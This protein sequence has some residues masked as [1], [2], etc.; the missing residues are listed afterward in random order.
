[1]RKQYRAKGIS[2]KLSMLGILFMIPALCFLLIDIVIPFAWNSYISFFDYNGVSAMKLSGFDNYR[3]VLSNRTTMLSFMNSVYIALTMASIALVVGLVLSIML[4]KMGQREGSFYRFVIFVPGMIPFTVI[5]LLFA[6]ILAPDIGLVNNLLKILH[7]GHLQRAWL[8][9]KG[10]VVW[11]IAIVAGWRTCGITMMLFYTA[12]LKIPESMFEAARIEGADYFRQVRIIVLPLLKRTIQVVSMLVLM[13]SF[14]T[15]DIVY[16]MSGGGPGNASIIVPIRMIE[17]AFT[18]NRF[19]SSAAM[20]VC[21]TVLVSAF[22]II[23]RRLFRGEA[24]EY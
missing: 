8:G 22:V 13:W 5:G 6:F 24:Y 9:E 15:Y 20:G 4:Y 1:M 19:G 7:L 14:K 10:T 21:L 11:A 2:R 16:T 12:I 23:V 17:N 3:S 18:Y